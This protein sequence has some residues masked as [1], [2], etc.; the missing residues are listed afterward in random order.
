[1]IDPVDEEQTMMVKKNKT[2]FLTALCW[3]PMIGPALFIG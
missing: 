3:F 2:I 1:M